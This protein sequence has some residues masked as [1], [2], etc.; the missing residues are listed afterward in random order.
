[1]SD[2]HTHLSLRANLRRERERSEPVQHAWL[3]P[4]PIPSPQ[5]DRTATTTTSTI[6]MS[7]ILRAFIPTDPE[8][9]LCLVGVAHHSCRWFARETRLHSSISA[10]S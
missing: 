7:R 8:Q 3:H 2:L 10:A 6:A 5:S 4:T 1:M 9:A